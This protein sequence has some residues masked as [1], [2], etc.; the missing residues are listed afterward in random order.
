MASLIK[1]RNRD[2]VRR[3]LNGAR[4]EISTKATNR[5]LAER[6]KKKLEYQAEAGI[7]QQAMHTSLE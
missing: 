3:I 5:K 1:R 4:H 2:Y 7:L 6:I